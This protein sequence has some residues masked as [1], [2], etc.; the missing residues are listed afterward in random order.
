[1]NI[2]F[3]DLVA[4]H[5]ELEEELLDTLRNV[6]RTAQFVGGPEVESFEKEWAV[7]CGVGHCVGVSSGTDA[8][9]FA[10]MAAGVGRGDTVVTVPNTFIATA[11]A[12]S[13]AG[14]N[15]AFVDIDERTYNMDPLKLEEYLQNH[16]QVKAV[17]PVHLYGQMCEMEAILD[18]GKKYGFIV[19]E[20]ACQ[21]H[22]AEYLANTG[23]WLKAGSMGIAAA[24]SFYPGKNLG[25]CGEGG[26][27][28]TNDREIAQRVRMLRDHGQ[29]KKY[30]HEFE[31]FNG[32]LDAIQAGFLRTKLRR[33]ALWNEQRRSAAQRYGELLS[34]VPGL[35]LPSEPFWSK[36]AYHLFVVRSSRRDEIQN[37]F[38]A[39]GIG[40]GLHYPVP[41]HLQK[42]YAGCG[43]GP[44][45]F[46]ITEQVA[47]EILSLPMFPQLTAEQQLHV[48]AQLQLACS[49][50]CSTEQTIQTQPPQESFASP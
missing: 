45:S 5:A 11:E 3:L 50:V 4:P 7:F 41:L 15:I 47:A 35:I 25:A 20:D 8:L 43:L 18:L 49:P 24:F 16:P 37:Q 21:A 38:R 44:G 23:Q 26:A 40:S 9:R 39:A 14:A 46:P 17:I 27:V 36:A 30:Y 32:R 6:L 22:G 42:A 28:T 19:I 34:S 10:L 2:P 13:Q 48:T 29:A 33:L 12:V 1:M 31:G